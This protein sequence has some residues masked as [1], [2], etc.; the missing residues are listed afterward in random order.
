MPKEDLQDKFVSRAV[1]DLRKRLSCF[2]TEEGRLKG[3]NYQPR[4]DDVAIST[5]P[6]AGTTWMQQICH[7]I[8]SADK[9]GDM[10]F[11]EISRVVPWIELAFDQRQDLEAPQF[12]HD[13]GKPR[14]F[15]THLWA[16]H[17]PPFP[18][19]INVVRDPFDV[20]V[21]FYS[22]FEGWFFE[23]GT[24]S[25]DTFAAEFWLGRGAPESNMKAASYF[26]HLISWY[27]RKD[28]PRVLIIFFEDL[29]EDLG[30]QVHRVCKFLSNKQHDFAKPEIVKLA[31][32]RSSFEFMKKHE[33]HFDEKLS[34][35][36]RNEACFL[37]KDAG[38]QSSKLVKGKIGDGEYQLG[39]S[40]RQQI[41]D[42]WKEI[43]E[44]VTGCTTYEE[45]REQFKNS[46][47]LN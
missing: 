9:G 37:P 36:Y 6:K 16:D 38:M 32:E 19:I 43:V 30:N 41:R 23:P 2:E 47:N 39:E 14:I 1:L 34:K 22:F 46:A 17:C 8:R 29:K 15:K 33:S 13:E 18:K 45:L 4:P 27:T 3:I 44:P 26:H 28:D 20:V 12:G 11:D 25:L 7:Q 31:T 21:S 5:T 10:S 24:V 35:L 42:K 40:V